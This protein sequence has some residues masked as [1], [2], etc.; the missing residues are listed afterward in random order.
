MKKKLLIIS[1]VIVSL[2]VV[3]VFLATNYFYGESVKRGSEVELHSEEVETV[4]SQQDE[5]IVEEAKQWFDEQ[6]TEVLEQ[7]SYD[8]LSLKAIYIEN[9]VSTGKT[10]VLAH[11][12][13][14]MKEDMNELVKFYYD[15][16]F[17]ILMPDARGHGESEGD[18]VGYGWHDR[19]DYVQWIEMLV[20]SY[21]AEDIF[22]HGNS[23]GASLVLMTSG[24]DLPEEVKGIVA[25]SGYT[26]V[27]EEL[28]HQLNHLY[29]LPAFPLLDITSVMTNIRA[30]YTF[31]EA[32][33]IDQVKNTTLPVYIIHGEEDDLVPTEMAY[34]LY[35]AAGGEKELWIV[36]DAG[37]TDAHTVTTAEF[38]ERLQR[39]IDGVLGD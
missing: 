9:E 26:T 30:G 5:S 25:D 21:E 8:D 16:G 10:V 36:P 37:H 7:I 23:M 4:A 20:D 28:T 27:K 32:S 15:Q 13:R 22:L 2:L 33:A 31:E 29:N 34:E 19:L 3:G 12:Y 24:E 18:Y 11:G 38:Q 17:D 35:D 14:G 6:D 39:F 1:G